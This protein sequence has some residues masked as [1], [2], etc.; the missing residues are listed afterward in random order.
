[1]PKFK[2]LFW[3]LISF[4]FFFSFK[5]YSQISRDPISDTI[6]LYNFYSES[7]PIKNPIGKFN[8][9][10]ITDTT[11]TT[12]NFEFVF[13][14]MKY[15]L[16]SRLIFSIYNI[17]QVSIADLI[18][19]FFN[20]LG[21]KYKGQKWEEGFMKIEVFK[22]DHSDLTEV[23]YTRLIKSSFLI[24]IKKNM[25]LETYVADKLIENLDSLNL[26]SFTFSQEEQSEQIARLI[27]GMYGSKFQLKDNY[28]LVSINDE[29][30]TWTR[31]IP[32]KLKR[33]RLAKEYKNS[34]NYSFQFIEQNGK[35]IM[36]TD[37]LNVSVKS[38][39]NYY[40]KKPEIE[41]L[42]L[43][44]FKTKDRF[45]NYNTDWAQCDTCGKITE[46][47][48]IEKNEFIHLYEYCPPSDTFIRIKIGEISPVNTIKLVEKNWFLKNVTKGL[49]IDLP[50]GEFKPL[51]LECIVYNENKDLH[52]IKADNVNNMQLKE[53]WNQFPDLGAF[54]IQNIVFQDKAGRKTRIPNTFLYYIS[55]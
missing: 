34:S 47:A 26:I 38:F 54:Y 27:L 4:L 13:G 48:K 25:K 50:E 44:G 53:I 6:S 23:F 45:I 21:F 32:F 36:K 10:E 5:S 8:N 37:T 31:T 39:L 9:I 52:F 12:K 55:K 30:N 17:H 22:Y 18:E 28:E 43:N 49:T 35:Q 20:T 42:H 1:M 33:R 40:K 46:L 51:Y 2:L 3:L 7:R 14:N 11:D 19:N 41:I 24:R 29:H 15:M 16:N